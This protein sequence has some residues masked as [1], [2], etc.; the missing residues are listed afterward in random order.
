MKLK[1]ETNCREHFSVF[2]YRQF[3][4][5]VKSSWFTGSCNITTYKLEEL[6]G[7]KLRALYQRRKGRDLYDLYKAFIKVPDLKEDEIIKCYHKYMEFVV[8]KLP[9]QQ[10][11]VQNMDEKMQNQDFHGDI[12][13]IIRP[14]DIYDQWIAYDLIRNKLIEKL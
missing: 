13:G 4:F 11:F 3:P 1:V 5:E 9:T 14:N 2:G 8:D 10:Q 6:L 12:E 7:T